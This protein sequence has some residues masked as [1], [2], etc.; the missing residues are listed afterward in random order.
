MHLSFLIRSIYHATTTY[1]NHTTM[2][3]AVARVSL[4][5]VA[6]P[7]PPAA[8][9][10]AVASSASRRRARPSVRPSGLTPPGAG[11]RRRRP[12]L[13]ARP[14]SRPSPPSIPPS[15]RHAMGPVS[16][17]PVPPPPVPP[18]QRHAVAASLGDFFQVRRDDRRPGDVRPPSPLAFSLATFTLCFASSSLALGWSGTP[19]LGPVLPPEVRRGRG[20]GGR[21]HVTVTSSPRRGRR[22][23]VRLWRTFGRPRRVAQAAAVAGVRPCP[24]VSPSWTFGRAWRATT[25]V[26]RAAVSGAQPSPAGDRACVAVDTAAGRLQGLRRGRA[27]SA[28]M[29]DVAVVKAAAL[30]SGD[31]SGRCSEATLGLPTRTSPRGGRESHAADLAPAPQGIA[32]VHRA[33]WP[34]MRTRPQDGHPQQGRCRGRRSGRLTAGGCRGLPGYDGRPRGTPGKG[35]FIFVEADPICFT[36][37]PNRR[38]AKFSAGLFVPLRLCRAERARGNLRTASRA[39]RS[40]RLQQT[41]P[42]SR[43]PNIVVEVDFEIPRP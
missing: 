11:R 27:C 41:R 3:R 6:P 20:L 33:L 24:G 19:P 35:V 9:R 30:P 5:D 32:A 28:T 4:A 10:P 17:R 42:T 43:I 31:A 14:A 13:R 34:L 38:V 2:A 25:Q 23:G 29:W 36:K 12:L 40:R 16:P 37:R 22:A 26:E 21:M 39:R 7:P 1:H 18:F 15:P 8:P